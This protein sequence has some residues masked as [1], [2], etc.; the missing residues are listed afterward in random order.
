MEVYPMDR[1]V[2]IAGGKGS[3]QGKLGE[4][5]PKHL[6]RV[7]NKPLIEYHMDLFKDIGG[8]RLA[9]SAD[10][11]G[12]FEHF[13]HTR[14]DVDVYVDD[15]LKGPLYPFV[16]MCHNMHDGDTLI[17]GATG[18]MF[19]EIDLEAVSHFH[20]SRGRP[21]TLVATRTFPTMN[22]ACFTVNQE[23]GLEDMVRK[24]GVSQKDDLINLGFYVADKRLCDHLDLKGDTYKEGTIFRHLAER[25][26]LSVFVL[27][28]RGV[29]INRPYN[30]LC[31]NLLAL[32]RR[33]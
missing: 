9:A 31:A 22:A 23:D 25:D 20:R 24:E 33:V 15:V 18:D 6:F 7:L 27:P 10:N 21:M 29:N 12:S 30:L 13:K 3:R 4:D 32:E 8:S 17:Y 11:I 5:M 16:E 26:A 14:E 1:A 19:G 2:I 28:P